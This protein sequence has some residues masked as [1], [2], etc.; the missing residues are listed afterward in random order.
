[1]GAP[2]L[3]LVLF[4]VLLIPHG[5]HAANIDSEYRGAMLELIAA[6]KSQVRM[7]EARLSSEG[8]VLGAS[9]A[10]SIALSS[11]QPSSFYNGQYD[12]LYS[13]LGGTL[14]L[15]GGGR[16]GQEHEEVWDMFTSIVGVSV[17]DVSE[18]RIYSDADANFDAF[19]DTVGVRGT[20]ILGVNFYDLDLGR[21]S[22][23]EA[24]TDLLIHEYAHMLMH[25]YPTVATD[26]NDS[27]W[28]SEDLAHAR[29]VLNASPSR[30][31]ALVSG[32]YETHSQDFVSEYAATDPLEDVTESFVAF[33]QGNGWRAGNTKEAQK[34]NFFYAYPAFV[35]I[36]ERLEGSL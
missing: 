19:V 10:R 12:S 25:E 24:L 21:E 20:W 11:L 17:G 14:T 34:A 5:A 29:S 15:I 22:E 6:L 30:R 36:K 35:Q 18:Y 31:D 26:F 4:L 2:I 13:T 1:M 16:G 9:G 32:Y 27:F 28:N 7:L 3:G 23:R 33:V 8:K